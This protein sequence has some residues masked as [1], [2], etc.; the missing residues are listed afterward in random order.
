VWHLGQSDT[1]GSA[2]AP[3]NYQSPLPCPTWTASTVNRNL[4][5]SAFGS[6][7]GGGANFCLTDGSVR[8]VSD[9]ISQLTLS[10]L[11]TKADGEVI[12]ENY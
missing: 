11:A 12:T 3:L 1:G 4:R 8:F 9:S 7:H 2:G 6:A 10:A 5:R